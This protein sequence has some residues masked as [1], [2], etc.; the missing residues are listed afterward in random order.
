MPALLD[1]L[2]DLRA[3]LAACCDVAPEPAKNDLRAA[4]ASLDWA[5]GTTKHNPPRPTPPVY[6]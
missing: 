5:I 6:R 3:R 4:L 1:E 2:H